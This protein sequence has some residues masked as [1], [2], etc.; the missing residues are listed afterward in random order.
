MTKLLG[1]AL[2]A[3]PIMLVLDLTWTGLIAYGLYRSQYGSLYSPHIV[4][5]AAVIFYV[6]YILGLAYFVLVPSIGA[7]NFGKALATAAFFALV[8]YATYDMTSL[9]V[10]TNFPLALSFIDMAWGVFCAVATTALTYFIATTFFG[11]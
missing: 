7:H 9:A 2:I 8:A 1:L 5:W 11:F 6:I 4:W 10:I 3:L